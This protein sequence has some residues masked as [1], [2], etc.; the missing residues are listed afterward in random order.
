MKLT[1]NQMTLLAAIAS[2]GE[3]GTFEKIE[4]IQKLEVAGVIEINPEVTDN[5]GKI[6]VRITQAGLDLL[7]AAETDE[8]DET[9]PQIQID[10][11]VPIPESTYHRKAKYPF[12]E[13]QA[14]QSFFVATEKSLASTVTA[15]NKRAADGVKYVGR[16][17]TEN[18][19]KGWRIWRKS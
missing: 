14:G 5:E 8:T 19:V 13:L 12:N 10:D 4:K 1:K 11:G 7:A 9:A 2:T 17:V 16:N 3:N 18:G 15:A 6:A